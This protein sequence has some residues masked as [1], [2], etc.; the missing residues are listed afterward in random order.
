[1]IKNIQSV[2]WLRGLCVAGTLWM[3]TPCLKAETAEALVIYPPNR[4]EIVMFLGEHPVFTYTSETL[5]VEN[6]SVKAELNLPE[7]GVM[8]FENREISGISLPEVASVTIDLSDRESVKIRGLKPG[9]EVTAV[10][11]A[12]HKVGSCVAD[13][14]GD[15]ILSIATVSAGSVVII[16][17]KDLKVKVIKK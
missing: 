7:V 11:L 1:M 12:G 4:G 14:T 16:T 6:T 2:E 3:L 10:T 9:C 17:S 5:T 13:D 15:A 8:K